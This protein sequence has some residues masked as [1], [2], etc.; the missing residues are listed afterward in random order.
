M[1]VTTCVQITYNYS[2]E[3]PEEIDGKKVDEE[4]VMFLTDTDD[5]VYSDL[6]KVLYR[7]GVNYSGETISVIND[8]TGEVIWA[9]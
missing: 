3:I 1:N 6:C 8:D 4:D 2:V 7:A 5:P 9:E